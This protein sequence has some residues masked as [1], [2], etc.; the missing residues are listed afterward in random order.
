MPPP[1][2]AAAMANEGRNREDGG[3]S[4][5][6]RSQIR[7]MRGAPARAEADKGGGWAPQTLLRN[8]PAQ[9]SPELKGASMARAH[10][11]RA[12]WEEE[13]RHL[14]KP[15]CASHLCCG[16]RERPGKRATAGQGVRAGGPVAAAAWG[17]VWRGGRVG[18]AGRI[19][20]YGMGIGPVLNRY[21]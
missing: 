8:G 12:A 3:E 16:R 10:G 20:F 18:G 4:G 5:R 2:V 7:R 21:G 19:F 13:G 17:W 1:R 15:S 6:R 9:P 11:R 14:L